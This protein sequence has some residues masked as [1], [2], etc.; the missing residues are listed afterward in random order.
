MAWVYV[1]MT[2]IIVWVGMNKVV[3]DFAENTL[4]GL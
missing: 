4:D 3:V 2:T 1:K